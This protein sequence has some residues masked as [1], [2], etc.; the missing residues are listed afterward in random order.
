MSK[1][2]MSSHRAR[3]FSNQSRQTRERR[4][5]G[6]GGTIIEGRYNRFSPIDTPTWIHFPY[7]AYTYN[8]WN[9]ETKE[10][11]RVE[12]SPFLEYAQHFVVNSKTSDKRRGRPGV[13]FVCSSG[14][15]KEKPCFGCATRQRYWD[16][17]R[18]AEDRGEEIKGESPVGA[19]ARYA[20]SLTVAELVAHVPVFDDRGKPRMSKNNKPIFNQIPVPRLKEQDPDVVDSYRKTFGWAGHWNFS[21]GH[22]TQLEDMDFSLLNYCANCASELYALGWYCNEC[23]ELHEETEEIKGVDFEEARKKLRK[24]RKCGNRGSTLAA[25]VDEEPAFTVEV[26][27]GDCGNAEE[28]ALIGCFDLRIK[29][30]AAGEKQSS[31]LELCDVRPTFARRREPEYEDFRKM[32]ENP[33]DIMKIFAPESLDAQRKLFDST[34]LEGV[35]PAH[36]RWIESYAEGEDIFEQD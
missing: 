27:C 16:E 28:G 34:F 36:T 22:L 24:C 1:M 31:I 21:G 4:S 19:G 11:E 32:A 2:S 9:R 18:A 17:K 30:K 10:I 20:I 29:A 35:D 33:L 7:Q 13:S 23:G 6:G 15:S 12:D 5:S 8:V 26:G 25:D 14:P 3:S